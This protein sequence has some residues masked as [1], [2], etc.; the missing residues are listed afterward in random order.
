MKGPGS[1]P[2]GDGRLPAGCCGDKRL[3]EIVL[4]QPSFG[5]RTVSAIRAGL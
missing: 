5:L 2:W 1:R 4:R 3:D